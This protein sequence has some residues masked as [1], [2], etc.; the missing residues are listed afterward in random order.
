M[1]HIPTFEDFVNEGFL[2]NVK[3]AIKNRDVYHLFKGATSHQNRK[4][5]TFEQ[6]KKL[7]A[8]SQELGLNTDLQGKSSWAWKPDGDKTEWYYDGQ[9]SYLYYTNDYEQYIK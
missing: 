6:A 4:K 8:K 9:D 2:S 5:I 7:L 3:D 1:K